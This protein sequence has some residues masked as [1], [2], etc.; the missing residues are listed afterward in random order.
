GL[1]FRC[2]YCSLGCLELYGNILNVDTTGASE[3]T[4]RPEGLSYAG[5]PAS[6][7]I[8]EKDLKNMAKYK[9]KITKVGNSKCVDPA[10]IAGIISRE[11][12]AGT[13]L[14]YGWGDYGNAFGLMQVDKRHHKIVGSWDSEE[15]LVQG[16]QILCDMIKAIQK[17]FPTWTKEQQLKG[18]I[19]AYNAGPNK[20][21][22]YDGVDTGTTHH[23]YANDVV[24]RAKFYKRNGY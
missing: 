14:E 15:H 21:Q 4:A 10:V 13:V 3:A 2:K 23:D 6:E 22:T 11:S 16:T 12:H 24:A 20:V 7:K 18:G 9:A 5:V 8:A 1:T 17:K 19:S